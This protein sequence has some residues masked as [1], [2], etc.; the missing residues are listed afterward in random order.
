MTIVLADSRSQ[1]ATKYSLLFSD[2]GR[3]RTPRPPRQ[4]ISHYI[5]S[6]CEKHQD[7]RNDQTPIMMSMFPVRAM[8]AIIF[9]V[10]LWI[11]VLMM[12][13]LCPSH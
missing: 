7:D 6:H 2:G 10:S 13:V 9:T 5:S 3:K 1:L 4:V 12:M 8:K 11:P